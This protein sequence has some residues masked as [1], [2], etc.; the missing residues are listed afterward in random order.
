MNALTSLI[1]NSTG[2]FLNAI[3]SP[4][5]YLGKALI[6]AKNLFW[7]LTK[8]MTKNA[9]L[10]VF[11]TYSILHLRPPLLLEKMFSHCCIKSVEIVYLILLHSVLS[12]EL[13]LLWLQK[14]NERSSFKTL[15]RS[16]T[17]TLSKYMKYFCWFSFFLVPDYLK[18][19]T[20]QTV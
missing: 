4:G 10:R 14:C 13:I 3:A 19:M 8:I 9:V 1:L 12:S 7:Y 16:N 6:L 20:N 17:Q 5:W 15:T 18:T 2:K 11:S